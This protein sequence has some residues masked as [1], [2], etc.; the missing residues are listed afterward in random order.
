MQ[1][2]L[3]GNARTTYYRP[4]LSPDTRRIAASV[5]G[6]DGR[7]RVV[8]A[9]RSGRE[10]RAVGPDDGANRYDAQW[11]TDDTLIVVSERG[12]I[13]N[14]ERIS[15]ADGGIRA[16]TRVTGAAVA[17]DVNRSD[18]SVWFLSLHALGLDVRRISGAPADTAVLIDAERFGWAG[19]RAARPTPL[20][21][22]EAP[23]TRPYSR[24][25]HVRIL[26]GAYTSADGTG[27]SLSFYTGDIIGRFTS[28][29]T[30]AYG[31]RGAWK[32]ASV[33][34]ALRTR[35]TAFDVGAFLSAHE[36]SHGR[37]A[38]L[39]NFVDMRSM[40]HGLLALN[41]VRRGEGWL[42]KTRLGGVVGD[43]RQRHEETRTRAFGFAETDLFTQGVR[44]ARG[45][46][47]SLRVHAALGESD[48]SFHRVLG[49]FRL[50]TAGAAMP[51]LELT[52]TAGRL[53]GSPHEFEQFAIGGGVSPVMDSAAIRQRHAMPM[54]PSVLAAGDALL[55]WR[56]AVPGPLTFF[57]EGAGTAPKIDRSQTWH[58]AVGVERRFTF[59]PV[60]IGFLPRVDIRGGGGLL[61]D[62]PF[63]RKARVFLEMRLE[64]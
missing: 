38:Q 40:V 18:G 41:A 60:P 36:P 10:M 27:A 53:I 21:A 13:P 23:P 46:A 62:P 6:D 64:P 26:P 30:F 55:A 44:G 31:E 47:Q 5:S 7:W 24:P 37:A 25:M 48:G 19:S 20:P 28:V 45:F 9:D 50:A 14:L 61:L 43:Y 32:G 54:F 12:G 51:P 3:E 34:A 11:L 8:I 17:P 57:Y 49:T 63:R 2:L 15:V 16:V 4:R 52:A 42:W 33:R 58:R 22:S 59:G 35:P 39:G 1:T 29:S 56:V